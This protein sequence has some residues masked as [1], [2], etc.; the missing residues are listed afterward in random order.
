MLVS[1]R[2]RAGPAYNS[3]PRQV[4]HSLLVKHV[5]PPILG[6]A[7][8]DETDAWNFGFLVICIWERRKYAWNFDLLYSKVVYMVGIIWGHL[9]H[10]SCIPLGNVQVS[11]ATT[12]RK[13]R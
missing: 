10:E 6:N 8:K 12:V 7:E 13:M 1:Q 3:E 9:K 11:L 4:S 5:S 2:M